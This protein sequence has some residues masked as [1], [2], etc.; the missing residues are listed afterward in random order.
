M[1]GSRK[2]YT[3]SKDFLFILLFMIFELQF[4]W[5]GK[6]LALVKVGGVSSFSLGSVSVSRGRC[7]VRALPM[8][9][10]CP[11]LLQLL[12]RLP[13]L[14]DV[15]TCGSSSF[16]SSTLVWALLPWECPPRAPP[17]KDHITL[18]GHLGLCHPWWPGSWPS[19]VFLSLGCPW[20]IS[21]WLPLCGVPHL[22]I[23]NFAQTL[24]SLIVRAQLHFGCLLIWDAQRLYLSLQS[25][26]GEW[27]WDQMKKT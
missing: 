21:L 2:W 5:C 23:W 11:Q 13:S 17:M 27:P 24:A 6:N 10:R 19:Q 16:C 15:R 25:Q 8:D 18:Q 3:R 4:S 20:G 14:P 26:A 12:L 9:A 1:Q 7:Q 22:P